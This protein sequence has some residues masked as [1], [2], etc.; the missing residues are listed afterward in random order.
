MGAERMMLPLAAV[1]LPR[2]SK[3]RRDATSHG[4]PAR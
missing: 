2:I 4:V 1:G 3:A